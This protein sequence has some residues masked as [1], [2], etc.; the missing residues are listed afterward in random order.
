M[1]R[2]R[3]IR[4]RIGPDRKLMVDANRSWDLDTAIEAVKMMETNGV[5]PYWLEEPCQWHDDRRLIS[6]LKRSTGT[7]IPISGG[8]S[9]SL[10]FACRSFLEEQALSILQFD[11]TMYGGFTEGRK[12]AALA[13]LNHVKIAPHHD[14]FLHA[15]LVA[16]SRAGLVVEAFT[17]PERDPLQ[18][19]LFH[20]AP[21]TQIGPT[22]LIDLRQSGPG[23]GL[24]VRDEALAKYGTKIYEC[25]L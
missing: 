10:S 11:V 17:D 5:D 13:E 9:E 22:G 3:F 20:D 4:S 19:E 18:A 7:S 25:A 24:K 8:E 2:L 21:N 23:L 12:L 1:E 15:H 16:G 6:A 14:C